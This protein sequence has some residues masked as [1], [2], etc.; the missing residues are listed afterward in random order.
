MSKRFINRDPTETRR[1]AYVALE[2][3]GESQKAIWAAL[4]ALKAQG[5]DIGGLA[6]AVLDK[7]VDI[8][9]AAPK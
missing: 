8:K 1:K 3:E 7:R 4:E 2:V 9:K 6:E 5:I